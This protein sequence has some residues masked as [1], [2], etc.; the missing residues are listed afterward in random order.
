MDRRNFLR[1]AIASGGGAAMLP[2]AAMVRPAGAQPV[3][4]QAAADGPYGSIEGRSP[5][6]NGL[7]LPEGFTSRVIG[8]AGEPVEGTDYPWHVFPDGSATFDDG[9]GGWFYVCN[10]EVF[11]PAELGGASMVHFGPD[12]E[13]IEAKRV[14]EGTSAN[15]AGGPTPWG[16]W[17]SCEERFDEQGQVWE[18]DPTGEKPGV[19]RPALG[20]WAHEAVAVDPD[21]QTLYLTQDHPEGLFYR[22]TPDAYP[23]LTS[24]TLEAAIVAPDGSVTWGEVADPSGASAPTRTQVPGA[25]VF[26]GNEGC[27]YHDGVVVFTSKGD[28]KVHAIDIADQTYATVWEGT[29]DADIDAGAAPRPPLAGVDNITVEN[30]S[31]D[32]FVAEDGDNMEVVLITAEG[33]VVPFARITGD[34]HVGSEVTGPSFNPAGDRLYFSSQRGPTTKTLQAIAG[35]GGESTNGGVTYEVTGPFRGA[36]MVAETTAGTTPG[37]T[38]SPSETLAAAGSG[39]GTSSSSSNAAPIVIGGAVVVAAA[40]AGAVV[41]RRRGS[42]GDGPGSPPTSPPST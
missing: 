14:L 31:G 9:D 25:T 33:E 36:A 28:N 30:G 4:A 1:A 3:D 24:G 41:L 42:T 22:F 18:V 8:I 23:D 20:R 39:N 21:T 11:V 38:P 40:V 16:T 35:L 32:L 27:W 2:T 34:A 10:S 26:P 12:G 15:C 7:L 6:A 17:L 29:P 5:D 37:S 13:I 19:A